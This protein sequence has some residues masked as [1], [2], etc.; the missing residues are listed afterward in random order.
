MN[1]THAN[2]GTGGYISSRQHARLRGSHTG[3]DKLSL[4]GHEALHKVSEKLVASIF[5]VVQAVLD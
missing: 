5:M 1:L 3:V 2:Y 4:L